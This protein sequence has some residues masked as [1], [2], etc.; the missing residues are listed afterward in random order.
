[1]KW[2]SRN[3]FVPLASSGAALLLRAGL[4]GTVLALL[5]AVPHAEA[6]TLRITGDCEGCSPS[7]APGPGLAFTK[8]AQT[9]SV[10]DIPSGATS[11]KVYQDGPGG[12]RTLQDCAFW[13]REYTGE[14]GQQ[15]IFPRYG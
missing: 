8:I 1:M 6:A 9:I 11:L 12:R 5:V 15:G 14:P 2:T 10:R 13:T 4:L 3:R 7:V